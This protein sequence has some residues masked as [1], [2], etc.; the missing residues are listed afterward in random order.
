MGLCVCMFLEKKVYR[1]KRGIGGYYRL[2]GSYEI[3]KLIVMYRI[4][5]DFE[6]YKN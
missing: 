3:Y 4:D 6:L 2:K 5:L 1:K